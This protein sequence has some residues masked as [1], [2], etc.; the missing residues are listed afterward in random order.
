LNPVA[1]TILGLEIRWYGIFI[2]A[3]ILLSSTI[4]LKITKKNG[5]DENTIIDLLLLCVPSA[6]IG[7]R[8]WYV[9]FNFE[10]Y[11]FDFFKIINIR[12]GGLAIH[13]GIM[14][15]FISGYIFC[16][17]KKLDFLDLA[18]FIAPLIALGQSIG[19]WGNFMNGE[20]HG[21]PTD[22]PWGIMA[23]GAK[24]HPTFLYESVCDFIIFVVLFRMIDRR[25]FKGQI[26][27]LYLISYSAIRF[28][29]E[30]LRTDSLMFF[31]LRTAQVTS[32]VFIA[33]G[34]IGLY[35]GGKGN[36]K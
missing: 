4:F 21:G 7:A 24:V 5:Y 9:V 17:V 34:L 22:L 36:R 18:D 12:G 14:G 8:I 19:R 25:K 31:G 29:I 11:G 20:A 26:V 33:L 16:K 2:A 13:G 1:F 15:A 6:I 27:C 23:D 30:S 35:F 10:Y 28:F 32:V 3:A